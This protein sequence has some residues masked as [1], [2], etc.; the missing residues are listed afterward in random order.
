MENEHFELELNQDKTPGGEPPSLLMPPKLA[1]DQR[2][3][4]LPFHR[5][6]STGKNPLLYGFNA[7]TPR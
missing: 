1:W 5:S 4:A 7:P 2:T 3:L 6:Q